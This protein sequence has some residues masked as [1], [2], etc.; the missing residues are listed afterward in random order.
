[1]NSYGYT[2]RLKVTREHVRCKEKKIQEYKCIRRQ[3]G[4]VVQRQTN[5]PPVNTKDPPPYD[6]SQF[7]QFR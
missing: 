5:N 7:V 4:S 6:I 1:M 3:D 2:A